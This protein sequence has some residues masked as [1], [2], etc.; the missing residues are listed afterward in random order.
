MPTRSETLEIPC[1]FCDGKVH[2]YSMKITVIPVVGFMSG[3]R[4][5]KI[6]H[7]FTCPITNEDFQATI[8]LY[9]EP[10]ERIEKIDF[11]NKP[12]SKD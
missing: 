10:D 12:A 3:E 4:E 1:P 7:L 9:Q 8:L 2:L 11:E 6:T 5:W